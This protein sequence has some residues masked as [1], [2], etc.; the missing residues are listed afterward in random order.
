MSNAAVTGS[1]ATG[2]IQVDKENPFLG[3]ASFEEKHQ[4]YFYGRE[5]EI[6]LRLNN[7]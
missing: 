7:C 6:L 2:N 5:E 3:L 1:T 4:D